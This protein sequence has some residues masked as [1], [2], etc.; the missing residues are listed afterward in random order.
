MKTKGIVRSM[1][2]LTLMAIL[3]L[4][5][6][7]CGKSVAGSYKLELDGEEMKG[8]T[9]TDAFIESMIDM[10]VATGQTDTLVL[11]DNKTYELTKEIHFDSENPATG[12]MEMAVVYTFTGTYTV[13]DN[14]VTLSAATYGKAVETWGAAE[15]Y[16]GNKDYD[17]NEDEEVLTYFATKYWA[18]GENTEQVVTINADTMTFGY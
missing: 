3:C 10:S 16:L 7:A 13:K 8:H 18:Q 17:S 12:G 11:N 2:A 6:V 15:A 5:V 9:A 14:Q 1:I 4:G